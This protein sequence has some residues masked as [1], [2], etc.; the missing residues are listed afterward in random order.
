MD[1][2]WKVLGVEPTVTLE[3][4]RHA[5]KMRSQ[6]YHPDLH[7]G[8]S[9]EVLK[10]AEREFRN[11][12]EAW[13]SVRE[14][15]G[16][17]RSPSALNKTFQP[18]DANGSTTDVTT[19]AV[20]CGTCDLAVP[21]LQSS[22]RFDCPR[23]HDTFHIA[24]CRK[25]GWPTLVRYEARSWVCRGCGQCENPT[26]RLPNM[27]VWCGKCKG[28][29]LVSSMAQGF[30]CAHCHSLHFRRTCTRCGRSQFVR[31]KSDLVSG[32]KSDVVSRWRCKC[33]TGNSH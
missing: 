12:Y 29:T 3:E 6:L 23:C 8:A 5:F 15:L 24:R 10:L 28:E 19:L 27:R 31:R 22:T 13:K 16:S 33:G 4:A 30:Q 9:P 18:S 7:Q 2:P 11:L 25:C 1:N 14:S 26:W 32:R 21:V 20:R 17:Q